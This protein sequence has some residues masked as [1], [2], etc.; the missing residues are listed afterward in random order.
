M[1][2]LADLN[3]QQREAVLHEDGPLL[4]LAGAG[5][6]KTRVIT[7]R[8]AHLIG[9][10]DVAPHNILAVTFTNKAA[11]E[12]RERVR[13]LLGDGVD[14][15]PWISTFH[16]FCL[17]ILRMHIRLLGWPSSF[18]VYD[19][20][21]QVALL[22]RIIKELELE[23]ESPRGI[24]GRISFAK[25]SKPG[26][27][28][29]FSG[30][31]DENIRE[32]YSRYQQEMKRAGAVDF[33]DILLLTNRL[34]GEHPE[35]L[36]K[37]QQR[38]HHLLVDE[39]QDTNF[40][41]YQLIKSLAPPDF[42]VC[43]VGDD[44]QSIY[45]WRGADIT[46]I[47]NFSKDFAGTRVIKLE[48][49]YR[50]T[51]NILDAAHGIVNDL[52]GR[53]PK[54]LWTDKG[55]GEL[56]TYFLGDDE[57]SEASF[58]VRNIT[59]MI[60]TMEPSDFAVLFRTNAQSRS[61]EEALSRHKVP[62]QLVGGTRFFDRREVKDVL[63]YIQVALNPADIVSLRRIINVPARGIGDVT[64]GRIE[65]LAEREGITAWEVIESRLQYLEVQPQFKRA[66]ELFRQLILVIRE[67]LEN[68]DPPS[69]VI[70]FV[71]KES[72]YLSTLIKEGT[73]EAIG[74][75][76]N[77]REL[78]ASARAFEAA[79]PGEGTAT[80]LDQVSLT[81][82]VDEMD[83]DAPRVVLMTLH[84]AKGLEFPV[85][86]LTGLEDGLLPH[87]RNLDDPDLLEEER[88]LCYVGMT[89]AREKLFLTGA[90]SRRTYEG[91]SI[92]RPSRFLNDIPLNVLEERGS[93]KLRAKRRL[94][95]VG[96]N[97][98]NIGKF[99]KDRNVDVDLS[100][101]Q[102]HT[103]RRNEGE[104]SR[105]DKVFMNKYGEGQIMSIEGE[106]E[107]MRYVVYFPSIG[108][109]KKLMARVAKLKRL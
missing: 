79:N 102:K 90:R 22:R 2:L 26:P 30:M 77:L 46:N 31:L 63:A 57:S 18:T 99:F 10:R 75:V 12:M 53:H 58:V 65:A 28:A 47:L 69:D 25:N 109:R 24:Q 84:S 74:R 42:N 17:R 66:L 103:E 91:A 1:A 27:D 49:N 11:G 29:L 97:I 36:K 20:N 104:F 107:N 88:R 14:E 16:S 64:L 52:L 43:A 13:E 81:A 87:S 56:V 108:Q 38:F 86:F 59:Q 106:G 82:D 45:R 33:D 23:G 89:R 60:R 51:Q 93:E 5:S 54:K 76:D 105:G 40:P 95:T 37:Y 68:D 19:V 71:L 7:Y 100:R 98:D 50:S 67:H 44:D 39:Y 94:T 21:D 35:V 8:I 70:D 101:L 4:V 6:G 15:L 73:E 80:Y 96:S 83:P 61:F 48:Q 78:L 32:I 55:K 62:Y 34:F 92:S 41:Q 85:V 9:Q 3:V 72:G